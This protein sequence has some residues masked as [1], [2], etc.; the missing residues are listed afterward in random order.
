MFR[1]LASIVLLGSVLFMPFWVTV[2]LALAGIIYFNIFL[3]ALAFIL[4]SDLLY[5]VK[6][7]SGAVFISFAGA[8]LLLVL[9]EILKKKVKFY[10]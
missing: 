9:I 10:S 3:E 5:G 2:I 1:I 7:N 4:L 6:E 8:I